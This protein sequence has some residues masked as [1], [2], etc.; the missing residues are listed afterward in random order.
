MIPAHDA[1]GGLAPHSAMGHCK[2]RNAAV[3]PGACKC[4]RIYSYVG[5][6]GLKPSMPF[7]REKEHGRGIWLPLNVLA[8]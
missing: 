2:G 8:L 6:N 5:S 7:N 4:S 3:S 1:T